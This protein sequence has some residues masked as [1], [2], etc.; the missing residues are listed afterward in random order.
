MCFFPRETPINSVARAKGMTHFNCGACPECLKTKAS[1]W[2]IRA[3]AEAKEHAQNCMITLTYDQ[4]IYDTQTHKVIGER[5]PEDMHVHKEDVQKFIKRL[6]ARF[7][8]RP[9]K[10]MIAAEYGKRT[11]RPHYHAI[12]FGFCFDDL[13]YY[14][15]SKRGNTIYKSKTLTDV[16][17]HGIC[18][19]DSI[20]I[21]AATARYCTKYI[22][23]DKGADTFMLFSQGIGINALFDRFNRKEC[24]RKGFMHDGRLYTIP[25]AVWQRYICKKYK[26]EGYGGYISYKYVNR[27]KGYEAYQAAR[28]RRKAYQKKRDEDPVYQ[29]YLAFWRDRVEKN[30]LT[31]EPLIKR[32][33]ALPDKQYFHYKQK[34]LLAIAKRSLGI[35]VAPPRTKQFTDYDRFI[36]KSWHCVPLRAFKD[37]R[38]ASCPATAIDRPSAVDYIT[39][40]E[41]WKRKGIKMT[42]QTEIPEFFKKNPV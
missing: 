35:P 14:K 41:K 12:L 40:K 3:T 8:D 30:D 21:T 23:K 16:W 13:V 34:A 6:R 1:H 36:W 7:P 39:E 17:Q 33:C 10:Y 4:F 28:S 32:L 31:K 27:S 5:L 20:N 29:D 15:R 42:L 26:G 37:C 25:R 38:C 2:A 19:V 24:D 11:H 18:T 22:S 9:F